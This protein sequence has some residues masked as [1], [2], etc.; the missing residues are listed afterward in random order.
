MR[1]TQTEEEDVKEVEQTISN[2]LYVT[3]VRCDTPILKLICGVVLRCAKL[4]TMQ[5]PSLRVQGEFKM[6]L[7]GDI[8]VGNMFLQRIIARANYFSLNDDM[9]EAIRFN[10]NNKRFEYNLE[11]C[12]E[13]GYL[14]DYTYFAY[15]KIRDLMSLPSNQKAMDCLFVD[16][17]VVKALAAYS[18]YANLSNYFMKRAKTKAEGDIEVPAEYA[19]VFDDMFAEKMASDVLKIK[20]RFIHEVCDKEGNPVARITSYSRQLEYAPISIMSEFFITSFGTNYFMSHYMADPEELLAYLNDRYATDDKQPFTAKFDGE[21]GVICKGLSS[22]SRQSVDKLIELQADSLRSLYNQTQGDF[23]T[24]FDFLDFERRVSDAVELNGLLTYK[25]TERQLDNNTQ[26][27]QEYNRLMSLLENIFETNRDKVPAEVKT[28]QDV[29]FHVGA[30]L[31][32]LEKLHL[33]QSDENV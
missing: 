6:N 19:P 24:Q 21:M 28:F 12:V 20:T 15:N 7:D 2:I 16:K 3:N 14:K 4:Y 11:K 26:N 1:F 29:V 10:K 18:S 13:D 22:G 23:A 30:R 17:L 33:N 9:P 31:D 32:N 27:I 8:D 5:V 25:Y